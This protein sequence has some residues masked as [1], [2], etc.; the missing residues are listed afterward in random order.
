MNAK[1]FI[2]E[3]TINSSELNEN[4][5]NNRLSLRKRNYNKIIFNKRMLI[6]EIEQLFP[7]ES[8]QESENNLYNSNLLKT[9]SNEEIL[10]IINEMN[11]KLLYGEILTELIQCLFSLDYYMNQNLMN[12]VAFMNDNKIYIF[13]VDLLEQIINI[14]NMN[15]N[16][17]L[18]FKILQIL[19]KYSSNKENNMKLIEYINVKISIFDKI[20]SLINNKQ[21][22]LKKTDILLYSVIIL[23]NLSIESPILINTIKNNKIQEKTLSIINNKK[24]HLNINERNIFYI[25]NF[26]SL[27]LLDENVI[28]CNENYIHEIFNLLNEKG[29]TSSIPKVQDLS[30]Y[31]LCNITS[32][33]VSENF[34]KRIAHS[35]IFNNIYKYIKNSE[36]MNS[37]V[38]SLKIVNNILTEKNIDLNHFIKSDLLIGLIQLII[39]Y[40]KNKESI[41]S[42]L[43]H[44]VISIFLYL[45]KSPLFYSLIDKNRKFMVNIIYLIGKISNQVTH[46]ILTFIKYVIDESYTISQL[47]ILN[48]VELI[49]NLINL[50]RDEVHN[51]KIRTM[52][53]VILGK[54]I[55]YNHENMNEEIDENIKL[56]EYEYQLK[57]IIESNLLNNENINETLK[58]TFIIVLSII[59]DEC[60]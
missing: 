42:D 46:D 39:N 58:K 49:S 52:D 19:F 24:I 29:I 50:V 36:N 10:K 15:N 32:L 1:N 4:R 13:L 53:L 40:E 54:I 26:F 48:N 9:L 57:G 56:N 17:Q 30:L 41:S 18:I 38:V 21:I 60:L 20:L 12:N 7:Q 14:N 8:S 44:H 27:N 31:C 6:S 3:K 33:F 2:S 34:Y 37:V 43:L 5:I 16:S 28:K 59:Y 35:N 47:L 45:V 22:H 51:D 23:Y 11:G 55:R 25:I